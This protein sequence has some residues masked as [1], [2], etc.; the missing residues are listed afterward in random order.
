L[1]LTYK[2]AYCLGAK[3][4]TQSIPAQTSVRRGDFLCKISRWKKIMIINKTGNNRNLMKILYRESETLDK[5]L[6]KIHFCRFRIV[7]DW[8]L[9]F[10]LL[11]KLQ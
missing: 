2:Q 3:G 11:K 5:S 1:E 6:K 7:K 9:H 4:N 10:Y 8:A